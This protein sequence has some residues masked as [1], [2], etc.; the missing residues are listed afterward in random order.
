MKIA[1][2]LSGT[3][4]T[5]ENLLKHFQIHLVISSKPD[6]RGVEIA[7]NANI[8][9]FVTDDIFPL[10]RENEIDLVC[11]AGYLKKLQIPKDYEYK[12]INI[13][14]SLLPKF[15]G[16]GFYGNHVHQAVLDAGEK[17]TGCTVH[18]V[19]NEY[20]AGEI[21]LQRKVKVLESDVVESLAAKVFQEEC[22]LY[23]QA[24]RLFVE[25]NLKAALLKS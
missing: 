12:V 21:I 19:D 11:L 15:G 14:P 7:R 10:L 1:V 13:H 2:L 9:V 16:K 18:F 25:G 20:D 8:P 5:L 23:P 6:V 22:L 17:E 4:R 3:G 24:V